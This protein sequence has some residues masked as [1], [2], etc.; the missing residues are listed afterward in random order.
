MDQELTQPHLRIGELSRRVGVS[1]HVLR[2]WELRYGLTEPARS[3]GGYRL[4]TQED[5]YR[6]RRMLAYLSQGF[7]AAQAAQAAIAEG[8]PGPASKVT[9]FTEKMELEDAYKGLVENFD[10]LDESAVQ[11]ILDRVFADYEV[12]TVL[13]GI[14]LPYLEEV[15]RR[16][17]EK[18]LSVGQEHFSSNVIRGR[19]VELAHG[20]GTGDGPVAILACPPDEAHEFALFM[21]GIV[22]HRHGWQIRFLGANTPITDLLQI[23]AEIHPAIVLLASTAKERFAA[24]IPELIQLSQVAP[25]GLCGRG[26]TQ[27]IANKSGALFFSGD[28]VSTAQELVKDNK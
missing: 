23:A 6:V 18:T 2:A 3:E 25:L 4:Y 28:P 11:A 27:A 12:E 5:E 9:A 24:V 1:E 10:R 15:G 14:L 21:T 26:A 19:L 22:L 16:W 13:R 20:W 17:S 8:N 7:A